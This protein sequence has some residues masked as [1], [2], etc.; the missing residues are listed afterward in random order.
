[1]RC[2][3]I[4]LSSLGDVI[5]T[6]PA[7][8][9]LQRYC[10]EVQIDWLVD[11]S[12]AQ[13]PALHPAVRNIIPL[14]LRRYKKNPLRA[15]WRGA[16]ASIKQQLQQRHYDQLIDAQG[17]LKSAI[18]A[19]FVPAAQCAGYDLTSSKEP[20]SRFFYT[21]KI[22]V[23]KQ[24][25]AVERIRQ[26]F[27]QVMGYAP[28]AEI[29]YGIKEKIAQ[30]SAQ[31]AHSNLEWIKNTRP[32]I[33]FLHATTWQSKHWPLVYWQQLA[34]QLARQG[35]RILLPWGNGD[36]KKQAQAIKRQHVSV[37]ILPSVSLTQIA[38]LLYHCHMVVAVDTGLAHL[39]AALDKPQISLFGATR[40][41]R[42][43][44]YG[45]HQIILQS[46]KN[47]QGCLR[48]QCHLSE[49]D[50]VGRLIQPACYAS[51]TP[52]RVFDQLARY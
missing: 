2:L 6:L 41:S 10:P 42:T 37:E 38:V 52:Q 32:T 33:M 27:A 21:Q 1:M 14:P 3:I 30:L 15:V 35:Y 12:F 19:S 48:K 7:I 17:L 51:L 49:K 4:K 22:K 47:C 40:A 16:F 8:S 23:D 46:E 11:E 34:D 44:P 29:D 13:I 43:R 24:L 31:T 50:R 20:L 36:E 25:H 18:L 26:L 28:G 39:A 45:H 5:H 9:D